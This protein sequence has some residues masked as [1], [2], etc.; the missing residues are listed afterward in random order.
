MKQ[1]IVYGLIDPNSHELRYIGYS[2]DIERRIK[3]HHR[4]I[5]L[6]IKSHK[7]NWIKSLLAQ[8]QKADF[9]IIE[10][11][12]SAEQLPQA[13][14]EMVEYFKYLGV[15][16]TNG[17]RGGD[18]HLKGD[19]LSEETKKKLSEAFSGEKHPMYGKHH[20]E[21]AKRAISLSKLGVP[22][23]EH[24][25]TTKK[26]MSDTKMGKICSAEHKANI[27]KSK[28]GS[29]NPWFG[30]VRP[31]ETRKRISEA[32]KGKRHTEESKNKMSKSK[33][34]SVVSEETRRKISASLRGEKGPNAKLFDSQRLE[35]IEQRKNRVPI[36]KLI[37]K[38]G[39]CKQ[40]II[41][42]SKD[43]AS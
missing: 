16:L 40:T 3:D 31:E 30:K 25:E 10:E 8:G 36:K 13:E 22:W 11:Y 1:H 6:K 7:N 21:E 37:K 2:S 9:I 42:I 19:K 26:K 17:T 39:V 23:G 29:N 41:R 15:E 33:T 43:N 12:D 32:N 27:G 38:Y 14:I 4:P 34:G 28:S 18:G 5:Y 20:S 24:S 35:I